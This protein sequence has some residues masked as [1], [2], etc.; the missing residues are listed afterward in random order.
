MGSRSILESPTIDQTAKAAAARKPT[1]LPGTPLPFT[2]EPFEGAGPSSLAIPVENPVVDP[3]EEFA[4]ALVFGGT[5]RSGATPPAMPAPGAAGQGSAHRRTPEPL[6]ASGRTLAFGATPPPQPSPPAPAPTAPAASPSTPPPYVSSGTMVM[7]L[8]IE[9]PGLM[10]PAVLL[11]QG[12]MPAAFADPDAPRTS[13]FGQAALAEQALEASAPRAGASLGAAPAEPAGPVM[14]P[15]GATFDFAPEP[16]PARASVPPPAPL[17]PDAPP[18]WSFTPL[19][20]VQPSPLTPLPAVVPGAPVPAR[21]PNFTPI[22]MVR[23]SM[24][25]VPIVPA[26]EPP[27]AFTPLPM[28]RP[29]DP[30]SRAAPTLTP[31][32]LIAPTEHPHGAPALPRP[33][34]PPSVVRPAGEELDVDLDIDDAGPAAPAD[35]APALEEANDPGTLLLKATD[36][37]DLDDYS[38]AMTL[39]EKVLELEPSNAT[40]QELRGRC[41]TTLLAMTESKL[42]DLSRRPVTLMTPDQIVW[43]NIDHRAGFLLSLIDG[44]SSF[45]EIFLLSSMSR[46]ETAKIL[47]KL[48][49]EKAIK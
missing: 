42:G 31:T 12:K 32:R 9:G 13:P 2:R 8:K 29:L 11:E 20:M 49:Q 36:L 28:V 6:V 21:L 22:S 1:P 7:G 23:P 40:A 45:E 37:L 15:M 39:V 3:P 44:T 4:P 33:I 48:L 46:L 43:L 47:V 27:A 34:I 24:T 25:P 18:N 14:D 41:E 16:A 38:G 17:P 26:P 30:S 35:L 10:A 5:A 19:S